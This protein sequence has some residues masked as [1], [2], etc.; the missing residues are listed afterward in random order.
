M[1]Q[2]NLKGKRLV[3]TLPSFQ[4]Q[5]FPRSL[6]PGLCHVFQC[7]PELF[8][9]A[10][11]I[12]SVGTFGCPAEGFAPQHPSQELREPSTAEGLPQ[13]SSQR[14]W[15]TESSGLIILT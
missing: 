15:C 1:L 5:G 6:A 2:I 8:Q 10:L 7:F 9:D 14:G 3:K 12:F 11:S 13:T 4:Q